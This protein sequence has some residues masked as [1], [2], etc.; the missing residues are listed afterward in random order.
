MIMFIVLIFPASVIGI[1]TS[2]LHHESESMG[3][4]PLGVNAPILASSNV[5]FVGNLP[6]ELIVSSVFA[7][8]QPYMYANTLSGISVY[9]VTNPRVPL[10]VVIKGLAG[11]VTSTTAISFPLARLLSS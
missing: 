9:D 10:L 5:K 2:E 6:N 7:S 8:D 3:L 4:P 11:L 1:V